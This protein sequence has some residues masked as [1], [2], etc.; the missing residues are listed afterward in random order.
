MTGSVA[1]HDKR[2]NDKKIKKQVPHLIFINYINE[3]G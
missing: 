1:Y 2:Q 3:G